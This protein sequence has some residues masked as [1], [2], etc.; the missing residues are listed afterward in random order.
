MAVLFICLFIGFACACVRVCVRA[1]VRA[2]VCVCVCV[3][4]CCLP[5]K[6]EMERLGGRYGNCRDDSVLFDSVHFK[7]STKVW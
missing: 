4:L 2:C 5:N 7:Y 3:F 1:C 6:E